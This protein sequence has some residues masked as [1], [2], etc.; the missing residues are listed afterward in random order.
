M[1][2]ITDSKLQYSVFLGHISA[3][4]TTLQH[5]CLSFSDMSLWW[6]DGSGLGLALVSR[7]WRFPR[8]AQARKT[9]Q[10]Q[11]QSGLF[12][13]LAIVNKY[14][15]LSERY[16]KPFSRNPLKILNCRVFSLDGLPPPLLVLFLLGQACKVGGRGG[17]GF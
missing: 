10:L 13:R 16:N 12:N 7:T 15:M 17:E 1:V 11:N 14:C 3:R 5:P 4:I 2:V 6:R 9:R 8:Y